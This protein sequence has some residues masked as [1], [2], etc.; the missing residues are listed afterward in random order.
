MPRAQVAFVRATDRADGIR[1]ALALIE[2][3]AFTGK[4]LILKANLNSSDPSPGSTHPDTLQTVAAWLLAHGGEHIT[5]V[6]RSGMGNTR[7]VMDSSGASALANALGIDLVALDDLDAAAFAMVKPLGSHWP[8][9]FAVPRLLWQADGVVQTCN[10]KTH[11]FGGHFSMSLKNAVGLVGGTVGGHNY[12]ADLHSS[13]YQREMIA[14]INVAYTPDL[15][16]LDGVEAFTAGGPDVGTRV[17]SEVVLASNDR[18]AID[19]VGVA[20]LRLWGTTPEVSAG[21]VFEQAQIARAAELGL[22]VTDPSRIDLVT[23]DEPSATYAAQIRG[24]LDA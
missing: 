7:R 20:V 5:L 6:D 13:P 12:M 19:A 23:D 14:E 1:R 4:S 24:L 16:V 3:P 11:R 2:P 10:L 9:G 8:V 18:I 15:I 22:G 21:R 17:A